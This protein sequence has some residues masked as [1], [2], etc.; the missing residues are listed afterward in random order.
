MGSTVIGLSQ[1]ITN[2]SYGFLGNIV[3]STS[4]PIYVLNGSASI[5]DPS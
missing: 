4:Q 1:D 3:H 2:G 5:T